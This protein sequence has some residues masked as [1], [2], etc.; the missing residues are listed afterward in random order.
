MSRQFWSPQ[1]RGD[2]HRRASSAFTHTLICNA[3]RTTS[4][5]QDSQPF[6]QQHAIKNPSFKM[7]PIYKIALIQFQP[8]DVSPSENFSLSASYIRKAASQGAQLAVLPEY[9]LTS[10][11][12]SHPDFLSSCVESCSYLSQYQSLAKELKI[13]IV[14]GTI[15]EVHPSLSA[16]EVTATSS[17][18]KDEE[19]RVEVRN[20]AYFIS[21]LTG[22]VVG[23]YQKRNLWHPEREHLTA[24]G[25]E[26]GRHRGFDIPGLTFPDGTPVRG[27]MLICWDMVFPEGF[28][29][30]IGDGVE[31]VVIPSFWLVTEDFGEGD[32]GEKERARRGEEEFLRGVVVTRAFENTAAVVFVNAGGLSQVGLPGVGNQ[33]GV[34]GVETE[35]MMVVEVDLGRGRGLERRYK[36]REDMRGVEWGYGVYHGEE[37]KGGGR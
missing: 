7:A 14:P 34:M 22:E 11:C 27:G 10:W 17:T 16:E 9:H 8:K 12:P 21:G 25:K 26:G 5:T 3:P 6:L 4:T 28:R 37:R 2:D 33:G 31:L 32:E 29:E 35:E 24:W 30:L 19:R 18:G 20:M 15:C 36:I 1:T 23:R 13:D